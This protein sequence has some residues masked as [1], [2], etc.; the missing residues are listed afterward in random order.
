MAF[1]RTADLRWDPRSSLWQSLPSPGSRPLESQA[2]EV[3]RSLRH[4]TVEQMVLDFRPS[5]IA[6]RLLVL[7]M[8][9]LAAHGVASV[10]AFCHRPCVC[11]SRNSMH[12][13]QYV[14][15]DSQRIWAPQMF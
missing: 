4:A 6:D 10:R 1:F 15:S 2:V 13:K 7:D 14:L 8:R 12:C 9:S 11:V 5:S 3:V